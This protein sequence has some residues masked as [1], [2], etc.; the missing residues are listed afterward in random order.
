M[1]FEIPSYEE[2]LQKLETLMKEIQ[3]SEAADFMKLNYNC[4]DSEKTGEGKGSCGGGQNKKSNVSIP[5][6]P[7]E[8]MRGRD[9]DV[10][11]SA[12]ARNEFNLKTTKKDGMYETTYRVMISPKKVPQNW[13]SKTN[14]IDDTT[15]WYDP[16]YMKEV[17]FGNGKSTIIKPIDSEIEK[18]ISLPAGKESGYLFR[19]MSYEEFENINKSG[20]IKT[21]AEYNFD[22]QGDM[23]FF[24]DSKETASNYAS[25][26]APWQYGPTPDKP[27]VMIK[28]RDP[29]NHEPGTTEGEIGI[30]GKIPSDLIEEVY[31]GRPVSMTQ[32][33]TEIVNDKFNK[34][35]YKGNG[36]SYKST[37]AWESIPYKKQKHDSALEDAANFIKLNYNCPDSEK[38]GEGPGSCGGKNETHKD[39]P[40]GYKLTIKQSPFDKNQNT[41]EVTN[42]KGQMVLSTPHIKKLEKYTKDIKSIPQVP[43]PESK[44]PESI[45]VS[46]PAKPQGSELKSGPGKVTLT[47]SAPDSPGKMT[48]NQFRIEYPNKAATVITVRFPKTNTKIASKLTKVL[49]SIPPKLAVTSKKFVLLDHTDKKDKEASIQYGKNFVTAASFNKIDQSVT[50]FDINESPI[51]KD[52]LIHELVHALDSKH[53]MISRS[54]EYKKAVSMDSELGTKSR[55]TSS[56][57]RDSYRVKKNDPLEEDMADGVSQYLKDGNKFSE[58]FPNRAK[59]YAKILG[60]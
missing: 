40:N 22:F 25:G 27:A 24:T 3:L 44:P 36:S 4:P 37:V 30:K 10:L 8:L 17:P 52:V 46:K 19:G 54:D 38:S 32:G 59:F 15:T 41:Y 51:S 57:A 50:F 31:F 56:Y 1:V 14:S 47:W 34:S 18:K 48:S 12:A 13:K 2:W 58:R 7:E 42:S 6:I 43:K 35:V 60:E 16:K 28:I 11:K 5:D 55:F 53:E 39:L 49:A 29:G 9:F 45:P 26:F 23:T 33:Y 20:F 21:S